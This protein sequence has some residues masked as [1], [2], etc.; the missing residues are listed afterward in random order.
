ME[1]LVY[2]NGL[3]IEG[4]EEF[5]ALDAEHQREVLAIENERTATAAL[6]WDQRPAKVTDVEEH[7]ILEPLTMANGAKEKEESPR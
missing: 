5:D 3:T 4:V 2:R 7:F 6:A 1:D